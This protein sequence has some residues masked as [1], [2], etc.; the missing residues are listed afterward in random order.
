[1]I[2]C[3]WLGF[4]GAYQEL[5]CPERGPAP[6]TPRRDPD[7]WGVGAGRGCLCRPQGAPGQGPEGS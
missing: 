5:V 1:M 6:G 2:R 7:I 4:P 3:V